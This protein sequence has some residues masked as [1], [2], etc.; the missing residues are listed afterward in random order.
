MHPIFQ[1][2]TEGVVQ[3]IDS[4]NMLIYLVSCD[5]SS[6]KLKSKAGKSVIPNYSSILSESTVIKQFLFE[7]KSDSQSKLDILISKCM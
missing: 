3:I 6:K 7:S 5:Y 4:A 2:C 1:T